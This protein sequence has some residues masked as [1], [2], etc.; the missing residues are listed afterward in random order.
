MRKYTIFL[1]YLILLTFFLYSCDTKT[2]SVG[3][4]GDGFLD[5]EEECDQTEFTIVRCQELGYYEQNG[6]LTCNGDCTI[7]LSVCASNCG[8]GI[9]Q[10]LFNE[11]CEGTDLGGETCQTLQ[12]G[13][14][15]LVCTEACRF[16][17]SG[18]EILTYCGD[19]VI[20]RQEGEKC[21]GMN[22]D[23]ASCQNLGLGAGTLA[24]TSLCAYDTTGCEVQAYCGDGELQT[25][26]GE[27]CDQD[28]LGDQTCETMGYDGGALAC[29]EDCHYDTSLCFTAN[30]DADLSALTLSAGTLSPSFDASVVIYEVIV[31]YEIE[32]I[33]VGATANNPQ[34]TVQISPPQPAALVVGENAMTITVTPPSGPDKIYSVMITR[35]AENEAFS[36]NIGVLKSV[37]AGT[38]QRDSTATNLSAVSTFTMSKKE[39]TRAQF[40][41]VTG[42]ADP[43]DSAVSLGNDD[44]A[45]R[46]NWYHALVFCNQLS[47]IEGLTPVYSIDA[48]T[49]PA[50]WGVVP[51][52]ANPTWNAVVADWAA[53]GYRLPTEMEWMWAAMGATSPTTG[54]AKAF[55]GSTG[56]NNLGD[57]VWYATNSEGTT[58]PVGTRLANELGLFDLS[59]NAAEWCWDWYASYPAGTLNEY[60][61]AGT[62]TYRVVRGGNWNG[63]SSV[64]TVAY[65][66]NY[67]PHNQ[68]NTIGF[69]VV[70]K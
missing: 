55:S 34:A 44:P 46:V 21:E 54:Y 50:D 63:F 28:Q 25:I 8:D 17:T 23:G 42:L 33:T 51:L 59:G 68:Y 67:G 48:S 14:G 60:R 70:R 19:G 41:A 58:H 40:T 65:R 52:S 27:D 53:D 20:Q 24:C 22:L 29:L 38:F 9:I 37:P 15:T 64:V 3:N 12:M 13:T 35:L 16:D 6:D 39:I 49:D 26:L 30:P 66:S 36:M 32:F 69:R 31:P 2:K 56:A 57:Y 5:P 1:K 47:M 62:G 7:N 43:S 18:C 61:G 11:R 4:C 10:T 45:Q